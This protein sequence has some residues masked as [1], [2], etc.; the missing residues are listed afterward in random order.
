MIK[1]IHIYDMDGTL[2]D[3]SHRF[4]INEH[5][6]IDL[7]YWIDNC[8]PE[9][10]AQD[11]LLPLAEQYKAQLAD[12]EIYVVIATAR[13]MQDADFAYIRDVLGQPDK[14]VYRHAKNNHMK[15]ADMKIAGLRFIKNLKQFANKACT[16]YED[17]LEYLYPVASYLNAN[18][19]YIPSKQGV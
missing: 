3:S 16:F 6:K 4:R 12:P 18:P 1:E 15:G 19:V 17:N 7:Q 9:K 5:G 14:I 8:T 11:T 2:V 10:I 13:F